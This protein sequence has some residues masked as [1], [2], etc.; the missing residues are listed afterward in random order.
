MPSQPRAAQPTPP[1][2]QVRYRTEY[3]RRRSRISPAQITAAAVV[4]VAL[5]AFFLVLMNL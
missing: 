3:V 4:L 1:N 5:V 2:R